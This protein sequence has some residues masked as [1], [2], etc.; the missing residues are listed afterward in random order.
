MPQLQYKYQ[1]FKRNFSEHL[2]A[3]LWELVTVPGGTVRLFW[4]LKMKSGPEAALREN[5]LNYP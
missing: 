2:K 4:G 1:V 5:L 3:N